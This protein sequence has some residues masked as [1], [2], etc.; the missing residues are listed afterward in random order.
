MQNPPTSGPAWLIHPGDGSPFLYDPRVHSRAYVQ[1][2]A[3][4][5]PPDVMASILD[6]ARKLEQQALDL[7][8]PLAEEEHGMDEAL[9]SPPPTFSD[10]VD[11]VD[12]DPRR[13]G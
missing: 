8:D 13:R 2:L 10:P 5:Y 1:A 9:P 4:H 6:Q 11:T 12:P 3:E 7:G